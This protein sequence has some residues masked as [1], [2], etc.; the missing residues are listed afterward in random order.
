MITRASSAMG[1]YPAVAFTRSRL[2][3]R[4][5]TLSTNYGKGLPKEKVL[6]LSKGFK[7]PSQVKGRRVIKWGSG[8]LPIK[9]MAVLLYM[10]EFQ[11]A[12]PKK[13]SYI[14]GI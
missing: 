2:Y 7:G 13:R 9:E 14:A 3:Y 1:T 8:A 11:M 5:D 12:F 4:S 10:G 6:Q